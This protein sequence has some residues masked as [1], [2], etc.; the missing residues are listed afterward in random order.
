MKRLLLIVALLAACPLAHSQAW[1]GLL[2]PPYGGSPCSPYLTASPSGCA[3]TWPNVGVAFGGNARTTALTFTQSGSTITAASCSNGSADC[4]PTVQAALNACGGAKGAGKYVLLGVGTFRFDSNPVL[5]ASTSGNYCELRGSGANST[6]INWN[7][8]GAIPSVQLGDTGNNVTVTGVVGITGAS[9]NSTSITPAS[10]SASVDQIAFVCAL[11][12]ALYVDTAGDE[13]INHNNFTIFNWGYN[14]ATTLGS[15]RSNCQI[16]QVKAFSG[17]VAT[18]N[19]PLLS[20]YTETLPGWVANHYYGQ[21]QYITES[22]NLYQQTSATSTNSSFHALS[23]NSKPTFPGSGSVADNDATWLFIQA[24]TTTDPQVRF[25]TPAAIEV[26]IANMTVNDLGGSFGSGGPFG[27]VNAFG[28]LSCWVRGVKIGWNSCYV[29]VVGQSPGFEFRDNYASGARNFQAGNCD[30]GL[31]FERGSSFFLVENNII[32]RTH[33]AII[34]ENGASGGVI[35]YNYVLGAFDGAG[36]NYPNGWAINCFDHHGSFTKYNLVEGN[37]NC[38]LHW[39]TIWGTSAWNTSFRNHIPGFNEL[40]NPWGLSVS[41]GSVTTSPFGVPTN[42]VGAAAWSAINSAYSFQNDVSIRDDYGILGNNHFGDVTGDSAISGILGYGNSSVPIVDT[43]LW[44]SVWSYQSYTSLQFG[45]A[46]QS[47]PGSFPLDSTQAHDTATI[48]GWY[49][50]VTSATTWSGAL[51]HTLPA[52]FYLSGRPAWWKASIPYPAIG[53]DVTGGTGPGGHSYA[54]PAEAAY[55]TISG[56]TPLAGSPFSGF[57]SEVLYYTQAGGTGG[58]Q[59]TSGA[60]MTGGTVI[61]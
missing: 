61:K 27:V 2:N 21:G 44:P 55:A 13:G 12:N 31:L 40:S 14:V 10:G 47:D 18:I 1:A 50:N 28:C 54:I 24:G 4:E 26:G 48:H 9:A 56:G 8:T 35:A 51:S 30:S 17:G 25:A 59:L 38:L 46:T 11:N 37:S 7:G 15:D 23:G 3:T 49:S 60:Q 19:P 45:Y 57:D 43:T 53:P 20:N 16:S 41:I 58:S 39:D 22:G 32:E 34:V 36:S 5:R 33:A 42:G 52:S 29:A 6:I